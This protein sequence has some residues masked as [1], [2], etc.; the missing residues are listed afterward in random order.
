[1]MLNMNYVEFLLYR[2]DF[3]N[4]IASFCRRT[5]NDGD[6]YNVIMHSWMPEI[7]FKFPTSGDRN[8]K[9]QYSWCRSFVWLVYSAKYENLFILLFQTLFK[10]A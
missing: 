3:S 10:Y 6:K 4:D 8:L 7:D 2:Q 1:M 9:F 5:L